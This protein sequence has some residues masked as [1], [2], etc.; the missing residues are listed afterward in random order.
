VDGLAI[1][2][3]LRHDLPDGSSHFDWLLERPGYSSLLTFR[4]QERIDRPGPGPGGFAATRLA[5]HRLAYLTYEGPISDGRGS[6]TRVAAGSCEVQEGPEGLRIRGSFGPGMRLYEGRPLDS[7]GA[8]Q[9]ATSVEQ[10]AGAGP[11]NAP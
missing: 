11:E 9:F 10:P 7:G 4:V 8:W 1:M 5:D 2:V 3:L 6:V